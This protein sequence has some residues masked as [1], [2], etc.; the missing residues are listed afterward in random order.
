MSDITI[1][2][3]VKAQQGIR[4]NIFQLNQTYLG[5][6]S[7]LNIGPK[8]FTR[9]VRRS[10][11]W[12]TEAYCIL[13]YGYKDQQVARNLLTYRYNQLDKAIENAQNNLGFKKRAALYPMVTMN[14]RNAT[15]NGKSHEEIHRNGAI[16][17][18]F[19]TIIAL[20]VI[21]FIFKDLEVLIVLHVLASK[22]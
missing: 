8:G 1:E 19:L 15:M 2:G 5:K 9:K 12:D 10:T 20:P 7:R 18:L 21:T 17:L 14:G 11:Y 3:D 6:D 22:S 13:L 16:A 4:F